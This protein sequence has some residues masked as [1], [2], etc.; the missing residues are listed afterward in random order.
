MGKTKIIIFLNLFALLL[1]T[2][3]LGQEVTEEELKI[4]DEYYIYNNPFEYDLD[5]YK[6]KMGIG[7]KLMITGVI[8][9]ITSIALT[10]YIQ[11]QVSAGQL[12]AD[13]WIPAL[14]AGYALTAGFSGTG[15]FGVFYWKHHAEN[16]YETLKLQTQYYNLITQ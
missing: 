3:L 16:Y 13:N 2:A 1:N 11:T 5:V 9:S 12:N 4:S 7:S 14:W 8:G 15:I 6:H 10:S